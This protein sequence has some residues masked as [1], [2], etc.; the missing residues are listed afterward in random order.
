[1]ADIFQPVRGTQAAIARQPIREGYIYYAYDTGRI[2]L[3]KNGKRYTM[4]GEG[5]TGGSGVIYADGNDETIVNIKDINDQPTSYY[6]MSFD[7]LEDSSVTPKVDG[8][9]LNGD[10]RFFRVISVD[11]EERTINVLLLAVSGT[12]GGGGGG[13][14]TVI[15]DLAI[16]PNT[17][18]IGSSFT[19]VYGQK[20]EVEVTVDCTSGDDE[21]DLV[22]EFFANNDINTEPFWTIPKRG[23]PAGRPI[24]IDLSEVDYI[25][26]SVTI[27][28]TATAANSK[29]PDGI[30]RRFN[31]IRFVDMHIDKYAAQNYIQIVKD[32]VLQLSFIPYGRGLTVTL[33][34]SV[35]DE[36]LVEQAKV[37]QDGNFN[38]RNTINVPKQNTGTHKIAL[39]LSTEV[40]GSSLNTTPITFE[41]SWSNEGNEQPLIWLGD[42]PE[43]VVKYENAIIPYMVYDPIA[44]LNQ[45][46]TIVNFYQ[47]KKLIGTEEVKYSSSGW[48][49]WDVTSFYEDGMNSFIIRCGSVSKTVTFN[50]TLE[51]S[52]D[53]SL[54][55][56]E[57]LVLNLDSMGRKNTEVK[58]TRSVWKSTKNNYEAFLYDFNWYNNG[59]QNDDDGFGS[60]LSVAN[61]AS[62]TIPYDNI[63]LGSNSQTWTFEMRFRVRN[64]QKY[65]TLVTE[66]PKYVWLDSQGREC[67]PGNEKTLEQIAALNGT[68]KLDEDGNYIMN[69][70][71]TTEKIVETTKNIALKYLNGDNL[72]FCIGTQEAY[73]RTSGRTVNVRYKENEIINI[74][75]VIDK[76]N[77]TLSIYLNGI[78]SGAADLNN[79]GYFTT[80][81]TPF[82]INSEYCDFDLYKFRVY[83]MALTMPEVIHNYL[84]DIKS[85]TLYDQNQ[86]ADI[87]DATKLSYQ[88]LVEYNEEHPDALTMPYAVIEMTAPTTDLDL[89]YFKN[90]NNDKKATVTFVNPVA[91]K[92]LEDG[93]ITSYEYY[94]HCPSY[95]AKDV[96]INVQG[97]SSQKYPRRNFKL[98]FKSSKK[99]WVY[100]KGELTDTAIADGA[101][102]ESGQKVSKNWHM[103]SEKLSTN[104]FTWKID[105]MESSG[106][107][108]TGFANLMGSGV[109]SK[110]PLDDLQING[111][112]TTGY[113][114]SVY[115]FPLMVFLKKPTGEYVYIG[116]YNMNLDK[117]SNEYYGFEEKIEQPYINEEWDEYEDDGETIKAHHMHP[118]IK[119]V[120]ECWEMR[121]NQGTWCSFRYPSAESRAAGFAGLTSDSS[122]ENPRLE[123]AKHFESR[124]HVQ[125]DEIEAARAYNPYLDGDDFSETIGT[126]N[127]SMC[128]FLRSKYTNLEILFNWLDSTDT[129]QVVVGEERTLNPPV[130][131]EVSQQIEG[132]NSV[133]YET[134]LVGG[135]EK[136]YGTFTK[137]TVEYRRQKFR[138]EFS[139]HLDKHYCMI[140]FIMTELLLCYDSRGKNMMIATW[141]PT[142]NSQGNFVWYPIFY[143]IDT[144]LGLNNV[145][146]LLWD[147]NEDCTENRTFSTGNSVLWDNFADLFKEE[148]KSTYQSLRNGKVNYKDIEGAYTCDPTVFTS[149]YAMRGIRP[150]IAIGLD[151]YY[152]YVLPVTEPW[153][154]QDGDYATANYLYACQGDRILSRELLINNRLLYMDSKWQGGDFTSEKTMSGINFRLSGNKPDMTSDKYL[155]NTQFNMEG[156]E[157]GVYPVPYFDSVPT[158]TITP[159]LD[160]YLTQFVDQDGYTNT[161]PYK[162]A[163]YTGGMETTVSNDIIE[164]YRS[165][166]VDEQLNYL[167]GSNYLSSIGDMSIRYPSEVHYTQG[168]RLLDITLGSD[169]PGYFND[170]LTES[171]AFELGTGANENAKPLLKKIILTN[172]RKLNR[173]IDASNARKLQEFRALNTKV[174]YVVFADGAPLR[175]VHLPNSTTELK[176]IQNKNLTKILRTKPEVLINNGDGTYSYKDES[177]YEGLYI[178][179]TTDYEYGV[180]AT[181]TGSNIGVIEFEGDALGYDSYEILRN[182]VAQ[183]TGTNGGLRIRMADVNWTPYTQVEEGEQRLVGVTYKYLTDHNTYIDYDRVDSWEEDT[184]QGRVFTYDSNTNENIIPDLSL[185]DQFIEDYN[186]AITTG[187][188]NQFT[189]NNESTAT[190]A[191]RPALSGRLHVAN[192][193][194]T[195]IS[196]DLLTTKYGVW[197]DLQITADNILESF[198][199]K[200]VEVDENS[201]KETVI[202][203]GANDAIFRY[204]SIEYDGR[205]PE[206]IQTIPSRQ[207]CTFKGWSTDKAGTQM[208]VIYDILT[209]NLNATSI[210]NN[211]TFSNS[212]TVIT[213]YAVFETQK[214]GVK[215]YDGNGNLIVI[216]PNNPQYT[217]NDNDEVEQVTILVE[218]GA[219]LQLPG[220]YPIKDDSQLE[221]T[222]TYKF[223]GYTLNSSDTTQVTQ[224][225]PNTVNRDLVLYTTYVEASVYDNVLGSEWFTCDA[226]GNMQFKQTGLKGKI[227][228]PK[229][230]NGNTALTFRCGGYAQP[231]VTHIFWERGSSVRTYGY[232]AFRVSSNSNAFSSLIYAEIPNDNFSIGTYAFQNC[233]N[234]FNSPSMTQDI[235]DSFFTKIVSYEDSCFSTCNNRADFG[236][237][238]N[239]KTLVLS[240]DVRFMGPTVFVQDHINKIQFGTLD[241]PFNYAYSFQGLSGEW[242]NGAGPRYDNSHPPRG[243]SRLPEITYYYDPTKFTPS[244]DWENDFIQ[245]LFMN[246]GNYEVPVIEFLQSGG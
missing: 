195:A 84:A 165:G 81:N 213:Y 212:N 210:F 201:G 177:L 163:L 226:N 224:V 189:N 112:D 233:Q 11:D 99:T 2:F 3:D 46:N 204:N 125:A 6:I 230:V 243:A 116:R 169:I 144:Q 135:M 96:D 102:L 107:Y 181:G 132:D 197:G 175:I 42:I 155:Q 173:F 151:E 114:T 244:T 33:H 130:E 191:T 27:K 228:L 86:L 202:K 121:D 101:T 160:L 65:G 91:D 68:P 36:E 1:M 78:L 23:V 43:E 148:I 164:S 56:Q 120:A 182:V 7:A 48:L 35:D 87:N 64:A 71:N 5:G 237:F 127:S 25:G 176:F 50:V 137:D 242:F 240:G 79:I 231:E 103:D 162:A 128:N 193:N 76:P 10:G 136:V 24:K 218:S 17:S 28:M 94:T 89:P 178:E 30:S 57:A 214:F 161:T 203:I 207:N 124:Y 156:Q 61:G 246:T 236:G 22:L 12:G 180:A 90:P 52:R 133:T 39:W 142:R 54:I 85:I 29:M 185:L 83:N 9:I 194:G 18:T 216:D 97:T 105:Y 41:A 168:N 190:Q 221:L 206:L 141:G 119:D 80:G 157:Y 92:L 199:C 104:K 106:S 67:A 60:Y 186:S 113:R 49:Y 198:I 227:T 117:S 126:T 70:A 62:V 208:A 72:G 179:D 229:S 149:S 88:K 109:Y 134:R 40:N 131:M 44:E 223:N 170:K 217:L 174:T 232:E 238:L 19:Y 77:N 4:G 205:T 241:N 129:S 196:E 21:V 16:I 51:G 219:P 93:T 152:K 147:Y 138:N 146:A 55:N 188:I 15:E 222:R 63:A 183:K 122:V 239:D 26:G 145:G 154:T 245:F 37:L 110:H 111:L 209:G 171:S 225:P 75:F 140:Y 118:L 234:L 82:T 200:Y 172:L 100:T 150:I 108:N 45:A 8:L 211:N 192:K 53:L 66:I 38:A 32:N 13:G 69:E 58:T 158:F 184:L 31:N 143:D 73:F 14:Q 215:V 235:V 95:T 20:S 139:Q 167:S 47:N 166:V 34:M 59:W 153:R 74:T 115:G 98:K 159:Y 123:S 220:V 187:T